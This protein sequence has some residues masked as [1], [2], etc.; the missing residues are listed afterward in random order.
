MGDVGIGD[1]R[2]FFKIISVRIGNNRVLGIGI[3]MIY[4]IGIGIR[5]ISKNLYQFR[6]VSIPLPINRYW[7]NS[8]IDTDTNMYFKICINPIEILIPVTG[9]CIK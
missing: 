2:R 1:I 4:S 7:L 6:A 3:G 9:I 5:S 8:K